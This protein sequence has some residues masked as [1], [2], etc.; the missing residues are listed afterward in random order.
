MLLFH[1]VA[2]TNG[3]SLLEATVII[4]ISTVVTPS[5]FAKKG[6]DVETVKSPFRYYRNGITHELAARKL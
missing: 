6:L 2:A 1:P 5:H 3:F 4:S